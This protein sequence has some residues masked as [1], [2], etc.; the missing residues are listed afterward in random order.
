MM[1]GDKTRYSFIAALIP[2][3]GTIIEAP[4]ELID[5]E[6]PQIYR[7]FEFMD[8]VKHYFSTLNEDN[9]LEVYAGL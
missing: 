6:N 8:F 3:D 2:K 4:K 5:K 1:T 7:P 9:A